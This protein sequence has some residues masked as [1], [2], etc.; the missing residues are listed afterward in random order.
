MVA[1]GYKMEGIPEGR[2]DKFGH[3]RLDEVDAA[4]R[5]TAL[6]TDRTKLR[7]SARSFLGH[8][9]RGGSPNAFDRLLAT[10]FGAFAAKLADRREFGA[11]SA[12]QGNRIVTVRANRRCSC[13]KKP[14]Q[15][16]L[17]EVLDRLSSTPPS[18][19]HRGGVISQGGANLAP[20]MTRSLIICEKPSVA[21]DVAKALFP[22]T[23]KRKSRLLRGPTRPWSRTRSGHLVEQVEPRGVRQSLEEVELRGSADNARRSFGTSRGTTGPS[24]QLAALPQADDARKDVDRTGQRL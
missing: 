15:V 24:K 6:L 11:M 8:L 4:E 10:R 18:S 13:P 14:V 1:E 23:A 16:E 20:P 21:A 2:T 7:L 3:E 17:Y 19:R 22:G 5:L 12:L 9:Q